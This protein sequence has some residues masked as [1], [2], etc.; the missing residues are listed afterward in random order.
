MRRSRPLE[1]PQSH[2]VLG[3]VSTRRAPSPRLR[4]LS[5]FDK[6]HAYA[7]VLLVAWVS[8]LSYAVVRT[9]P[10]PPVSPSPKKGTPSSSSSSSL[11]HFRC[12]AE[13]AVSVAEQVRQLSQLSISFPVTNQVRAAC[14]T[15]GTHTKSAADFLR[16]ADL[17]IDSIW[18]REYLSKR[19]NNDKENLKKKSL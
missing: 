18:D 15:V 10:V 6:R 4:T 17:S 5:G 3:E 13:H 12:N 16:L 9:T 19:P 8:L 2:E 1:P 14:R 7:L 11:D